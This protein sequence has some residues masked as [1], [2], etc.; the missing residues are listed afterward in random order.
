MTNRDYILA[1]EKAMENGYP[2]LI[3]NI[4]EELD[5]ILGKI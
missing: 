1:L 2:L 5:P 4:G 3:E